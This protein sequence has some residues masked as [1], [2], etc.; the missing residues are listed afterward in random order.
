MVAELHT[1][2]TQCIVFLVLAILTRFSF[3]FHVTNFV[4]QHLQYAN[5]AVEGLGDLITC[6]DVR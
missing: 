5:T 1:S 4:S 2:G 3:V 6:D